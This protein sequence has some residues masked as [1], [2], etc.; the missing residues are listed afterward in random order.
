MDN[1]TQVEK[2]E[3]AETVPQNIV[4]VEKT[5]E[6]TKKDTPALADPVKLQTIIENDQNKKTV[7]TD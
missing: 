3:K 6:P 4:T 2:T 1:N 7:V 5:S